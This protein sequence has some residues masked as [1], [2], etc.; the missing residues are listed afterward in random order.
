MNLII[1]S[2]NF[3]SKEN[4]LYFLK[5]FKPKIIEQNLLRIKEVHLKA[6]AIVRNKKK[7]KI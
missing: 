6:I 1:I 2:E 5:I 3:Q 7:K 4:L